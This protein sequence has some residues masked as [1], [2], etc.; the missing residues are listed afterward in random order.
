MLYLNI[1]QSSR[2]GGD[3]AQSHGV[4]NNRQT[5]LN[6]YGKALDQLE[7]Q[8]EDGWHKIEHLNPNEPSYTRGEVNH[9]TGEKRYMPTAIEPVYPESIAVPLPKIGKALQLLK[10]GKGAAATGGT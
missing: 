8:I 7:Y 4:T 3:L 1:L 2:Q 5:Q 10:I 9:I 6:E